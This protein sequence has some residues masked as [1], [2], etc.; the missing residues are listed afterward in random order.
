MSLLE[1]YRQVSVSDLADRFEVS[2]LTIRR[3]LDEL[4]AHASFPSYAWPRYLI[5]STGL[6]ST[7]YRKVRP[8]ASKLIKD[9]EP[10]SSHQLN[11]YKALEFITAHGCY[12]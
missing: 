7:R 12:Q 5:H 11:R 9:G 4:E 1:Q 10:R 8:A 3:G 2:S 6:S